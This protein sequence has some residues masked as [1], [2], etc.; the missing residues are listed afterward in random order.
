[1]K[2]VTACVFNST[3]EKFASSSKDATL[4]IWS[5]NRFNLDTNQLHTIAAAHSDWIT[6]LAWSNSS[7]FILSAS[8]DF[9][10]KIWNAETGK[11]TSKLTGHKANINSCS[12]QYGCAVSTSSDGQV[13]VWSHKGYEIASLLGHQKRV[14]ACDL[15]FKIKSK[16][17]I[18]EASRDKTQSW[19]ERVDEAEYEEKIK[20][21][22]N[23]ILIEHVYL[24]TGS[25]DSTI[26]VWKPNESDWL[27]SLEKHNKKIN[28]VDLSESGILATASTDATV[29][30]FDMKNFFNEFM[31][32]RFA[33]SEKLARNH[34][35]E[36]TSIAFSKSGRFLFTS[37]ADGMLLIWACR[38]E[39][40]ECISSLEL[41]LEIQ[42]H[43]RSLNRVCVLNENEKF[44]HSSVTFATC[45]DDC[46]VKIWKLKEDSKKSV[47][48]ES[49][50]TIT[51]KVAVFHI[52]NY[53]TG[54]EN[55]LACF[56][57]ETYRIHLKI[58]DVNKNFIPVGNKGL[59]IV[60]FK[61]IVQQVKQTNS[62]V[63]ISFVD[64]EIYKLSL[65][66]IFS[67]MQVI[68]PEIKNKPP[69]Y[70]VLTANSQHNW[71]TCVDEQNKDTL[72]ADSNG[73]LFV[74]SNI[75]DNNNNNKLEFKR[76]IHSARVTEIFS[77][78]TEKKSNRFI[79][80]SQDC[81][82]KMWTENGD[83]QLGQYN[84]NAAITSIEM[85]KCDLPNNSKYSFVLGDQLGNLHLIV[86]HD[87]D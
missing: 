64:D 18:H 8:N 16:K 31:C 78:K 2:K 75:D 21:K 14:N 79:T 4:I 42:A 50:K 48:I 34:N 22:K 53:E 77:F 19:A 67:R 86:W 54:K 62:Y 46:S 81:T 38:R 7:E 66:E 65:L 27:S 10:L 29:N 36:I 1:M 60:G 74:N 17:Q 72:A 63:Y 58:Y 52:F 68:R 87:Q 3:G 44:N 71:Y 15:Y 5:L 32:G 57:I 84:T 49:V 41:L 61:S 11:E 12:F 23:E 13:K 20:D 43:E 33:T 70:Q 56:V 6:D 55:Y 39:E 73:G 30:I 59:Q 69:Y 26:R 25:D 40:N 24:V 82:V 9:S 37:S 51:D 80:A 35:D 45:S 47:N 76:S 83:I 85:L 28:S